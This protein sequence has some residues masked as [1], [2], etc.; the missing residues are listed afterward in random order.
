MRWLEQRYVYNRQNPYD[1]VQLVR[2]QRFNLTL[3]ECTRDNRVDPE[4]GKPYQRAG[5]YPP[6][7]FPTVAP[8]VLPTQWH[9]TATYFALL[10]VLALTITFVWAYQIGRPHS[11]AGGVFLGAAAVAVFGHYR[12]LQVGQYAI[13]VNA[14]LIGVYWLVQKSRPFASGILFGLAMLKP[15]ISVLFALGFLVRRQWRA[16]AA[17]TAYVVLASLVTWVM[18][19]TN[20]IEMLAQMYTL[21]QGWADHP[22]PSIHEQIPLGCNSF[23]SLLLDLHLDR[24]VATPLAAIT[25]LLLAAVLMWLWRNSSTLTLFAIAATTGRLWSYHRPYDDVMLIFLMVALGK[26]VMTHRSIGTVLAFCLVGLSLWAPFP[27]RF[28]PLALQIALMSSWLFGL[29]I[30]L[31]WEPRS[32][33]I[34]D[35]INLNRNHGFCLA[36]A[37]GAAQVFVPRLNVAVVLE[38][39]NYRR[40]A[41]QPFAWPNPQRATRTASS[42]SLWASAQSW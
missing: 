36:V 17:A 40:T 7:T 5:G 26:L 11:R 30:L 34:E 9:F 42:T 33:W 2:A 8:I 22:N 16:L 4:I 21:A 24:K 3:P 6:W 38:A 14:L 29:A 23:S 19:R 27:I 41:W 10:N 28:P 18:T 37:P 1:V 20:P 39:G 15:Q 32:G 35:Q 12:S 13:L 31:A 25:G